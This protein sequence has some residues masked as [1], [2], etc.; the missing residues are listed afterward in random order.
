MNFQ[1]IIIVIAAIILVCTLIPIAIAIY[2]SKYSVTF[3]PVVATCP[4]YWEEQSIGNNTNNMNTSKNLGVCVNIK[5][6]GNSSCPKRMNFTAGQW[7][8][9]N[10]L[11][12]KAKWAKSCD[13]T[14]DG[15]TNNIHACK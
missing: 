11:C 1:I 14:W 13:L 10:S 15:I 7:I 5:G 4:D 8:G 3:P 6:L 9:S 2:Y 12:N